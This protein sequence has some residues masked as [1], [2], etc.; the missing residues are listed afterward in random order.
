L[1]PQRQCFNVSGNDRTD[2]TIDRWA[3]TQQASKMTKTLLNRIIA[4]I[5]DYGIIAA[6]ATVLFLVSSTIFSIFDWKFSGSPYLGQ[7]IGF[8]TLTFPVITY[9]YLTEKSNWKGT[10]GKKLR[11]L[12]VL[13]DLNKSTNNILLRNILKYLPWEIAHTG[14]HW[15]NYF[16]SNGIEI[17]LWTWLILILPQVVAIVY[18]VSIV[19]SKGQSSVYDNISKTKIMYLNTTN[20]EGQNHSR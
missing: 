16:T 7:L 11:K 10:V 2:R 20:F 8:I 18:L 3:S 12:C 17:P 19:L 6:Y 4:S 13:T 1:P 5:I 14:V 15:T 9:S